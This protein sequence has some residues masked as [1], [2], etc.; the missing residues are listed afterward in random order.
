MWA[1]TIFTGVP[2]RAQVP[3]ENLPNIRSDSLRSDTARI[4]TLSKKGVAMPPDSTH[5]AAPKREPA[6]FLDDVISGKNK[7]SLI[8]MPRTKMVYIYQE[9][10][11]KYQDINLQADRMAV[12]METKEIFAYGV[13]DTLGKRSRPKFIDGGSELTMDTV[14]YN[15]DSKKAFIKGVATQEGEGFM[16]GEKVKKMPDNTTNI[17][18][19]R[20]TTC[21]N[22]EHPHF[23]IEMTKAKM[24]PQ[25]KMIMGPSYIVME[26]VPLYFLGVPFGFFP[27]NPNRTS[28]FIMPTYG[29]EQIKG[30]F[31]RDGGYYFA[32]NDYI[33]ATATASIYTL[34]SWDASIS[35]RYIKRYRFSG[36]LTAHYSKDIV[37]ERGAADYVNGNNYSVA[38]TH[39]Q[40]PR[41]RPNST[42]SA[43]VNF[44]TGGYSKYS[45]TNMND[46]L[47][48]QTNSSVSYSKSW[49][50][51]PFSF[52][53]NMQLSQNSR[54]S[55]YS[56]SF[57]NIVFNASKFF[58]FQRKEVVGKL[59]WYEK[60]SMSYS[61]TLANS[62]SNVKERDMFTGKMV[63]VMQ[64]GVNHT[65]PISTSLNVLKYI[66]ISP[67]ANTQ[68]RWYFRRIDKEW[69]AAANKVAADT[70]YGFWSSYNYNASVSA[71]TKIYGTFQFGPK[72]KIQAVRHVMS[73][74]VSFGFTPDFSQP[75]YGFYKSLQTDSTGTISYYSP[76][77]GSMYGVPGSGKS[78]SMSFSISNT[79]EMKVLSKADTS[80]IKKIKL[81]ENFSLSSS[82]NFLAD[83]LNLAPFSLSLRTGN[84]FGNFALQLSAT[85]DP[86]ELDANGRRINKLMMARGVPG[87]ITSTGWSFGYSFNSSKKNQPTVN[88]INNQPIAPPTASDFFSSSGATSPG[89]QMDAETRREMLSKMYYDFDIPWNFSF[90]YSLSYSNPSGKSNISQTLGFNGSINLTPKWGITFNGGYD[91]ATK[92]L[93]PGTFTLV[94]DLH[95]WQMNFTFVPVG[96]R[97]SWSFNIGVKSALLQDLKYD[98]QSSFYDNLYD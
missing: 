13:A 86:Y 91:F 74:S 93:T 62:V 78:A 39:Q 1:L 56:I 73:P 15:L 77:E 75:K 37:G 4:D 81:I 52:S 59:R 44:S 38:W 8:Y 63:D 50:G 80:G 43:S 87:R 33:D 30:F 5:T 51:T 72:S 98:K 20:Y 10:D 55:T 17:A 21:D 2:I 19:G 9:G 97:K 90:N 89:G 42:F 66:N 49:P 94:R 45:A 31:L 26:D 64:N 46:Y 85:L 96:F 61:G 60:I 84:L 35:S 25:K 16:I 68:M 28:G 11:V 24:I 76:F 27:I 53:T 71:S 18:H 69:D 79:L 58:P 40:D 54:D 12:N 32:F 82:W 57:P 83:S 95:C 23:Y 7:D 3:S 6:K 88:D 47:N 41:F 65:V 14:R 48:T 34:G 36:S 29:E 92:T 22:L 70:S 67:S